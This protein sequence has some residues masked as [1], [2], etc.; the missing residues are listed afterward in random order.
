MLRHQYIDVNSAVDNVR[1][2]Q[3]LSYAVQTWHVVL[4]QSS[5]ADSIQRVDWTL[6]N[7]RAQ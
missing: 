4:K 5:T 1:P 3:A 2:T 6:G 7:L